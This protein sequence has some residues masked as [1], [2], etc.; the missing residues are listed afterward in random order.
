LSAGDV[1]YALV[2]ATATGKTDLAERLADDLGA[3]IVCADSRQVFADLDLGTGK[4]SVDERAARPHHLFDALQ[5][6][7]AASAGWYAR[8]AARAIDGIRSRGRLPLLVGGA[9]LYLKALQQ[10]LAPE[11]AID[12]TLRARLRTAYRELPLEEL[13]ARLSALAPESAQRIRPADRQRLSRALEV[14]EGSGRTLGWWQRQPVA[15]PV[16]GEWR[17]IEVRLDTAE[18]DRRIA[19][20]TRGMFEHGLIE[21]TRA[22]SE[23]GLE[24]KLRKLRAVGY[25]EALDLLAGRI[26][27]E[28]AESRT[29]LRTRQL[30]KRQRTWF[31]HQIEA[32]ILDGSAREADLVAGA[33]RGF[34]SGRAEGPPAVDTPRGSA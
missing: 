25:D 17:V 30:A 1:L 2:G 15:P 18:L 9:G 11:P 21:E 34:E 22:L 14:V 28:E 10:G 24:P 5:L 3:E 4:P 27:R 13:R 20:R 31:R 29:R 23:R 16:T 7:E 32:R 6:G 33:R 8:E 19:A 12:P 26:T